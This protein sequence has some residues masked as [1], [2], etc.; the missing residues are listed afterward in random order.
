MCSWNSFPG[1]AAFWPPWFTQISLK[2]F[3][4]GEFDDDGVSKP[5]F[6]MPLLPG[7]TL[8]DLI[9]P[10]AIPL[11]TSR[12]VDIISQACRGLQAAHEQ[13][14]LH[15]DIKPRN[16]F[17]MRDDAVKI[18][19]FGVAHLVGNNSTGFRGTPLYMSPEQI[20]FKQL[21]NR[22]D[23]FSLAVV[24]YETLTAS[25]PFLRRADRKDSD[26]E[27]A[28]AI[29]AHLPPLA[30]E[31]NPSVSRA[32]AQVVAKGMAKDTWSRFESAAAFSEALR[33][34][35]RNESPCA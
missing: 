6:V 23:I 24:C 9:Y 28:D 33:K 30:S 4:M 8:H 17:V 34:A 22:S 5:Y 29:A 1:S 20:S 11:S 19:D 31:L 16:I 13:G 10:G 7:R 18:I 27:I 3:D 32:V 25:H 35:L 2:I 26:I 12:C 21:T 14:L 15:R